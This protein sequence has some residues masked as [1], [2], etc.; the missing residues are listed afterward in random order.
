MSLIGVVVIV[1]WS[2]LN[3]KVPLNGETSG[4]LA[5]RHPKT[6]GDQN[7]TRGRR[8]RGRFRGNADPT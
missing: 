8:R 5:M 6:G 1:V 3:D 7:K 4:I 2:R